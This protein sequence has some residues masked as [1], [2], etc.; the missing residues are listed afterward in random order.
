MT[1]RWVQLV[2]L[3]LAASNTVVTT[4]D[5]PGAGKN[6]P[7]QPFWF[8]GTGGPPACQGQPNPLFAYRFQNCPAMDVQNVAMGR[9]TL[10]ASFPFGQPQPFGFMLAPPQY[11]MGD[12]H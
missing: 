12:M 7:Q 10:F 2:T 6:W 1:F 4:G 5:D 11:S 3:F 9:P 8:N